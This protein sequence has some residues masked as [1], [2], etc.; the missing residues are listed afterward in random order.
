MEVGMSPNR[1]E[2]IKDWERKNEIAKINRDHIDAMKPQNGKSPWLS[3]DEVVVV[4]V[5]TVLSWR[6]RLRV[7]L[8]GKIWVRFVITPKSV[9]PSI[10]NPFGADVDSFDLVGAIG[11]SRLNLRPTQAD[12]FKR[13][14]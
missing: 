13:A 4:R 11:A 8:S 12:V 6:E 10:D 14:D 5:N 1:Y 3:H 2:S 9:V 7:L